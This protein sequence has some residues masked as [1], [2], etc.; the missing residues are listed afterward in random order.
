MQIR[1]KVGKTKFMAVENFKKILEEIDDC[2]KSSLSYPEM[3]KLSFQVKQ[4]RVQFFL[5]TKCKIVAVS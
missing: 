4:S 2:R 3:F 1:F 5:L